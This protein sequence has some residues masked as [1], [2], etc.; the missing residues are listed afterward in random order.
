[1]S[2]PTK[3][4][5][6]TAF[7]G[8]HNG[9]SHEQKRQ[10]RRRRSGKVDV[11]NTPS[12]SKTTASPAALK[13]KTS[14]KPV[15]S[16]LK[17]KDITTPNTPTSNDGK[18]KKQNSAK[19]PTKALTPN[20]KPSDSSKKLKEA[21]AALDK[22]ITAEPQ[23][24]A[25]TKNQRKKSTSL[26]SKSSHIQSQL[27]G[28]NGGNAEG[29]DLRSKALANELISEGPALKSSKRPRKRNTNPLKKR[30]TS[31][32]NQKLDHLARTTQQDQFVKREQKNQLVKKDK[33]KPKAL[34]NPKT[35]KSILIGGG[36]RLS[37]GNGGMF[38][39]QDP[40]LTADGQYLILPTHS[41]IQVYSTKTSLL[42]RSF[43]V[44]PRSDITCCSL[45]KADPKKLYV[46]SSRGL[47]SLWDWTAAAVIG[48]CNAGN[49]S[50]QVLPLCQQEDKETI[51]V[52]QIDAQGSRRLAA[53]SVNTILGNFTESDTVLQRINLSP[54]FKSYAQGT[55]LLACV[56]NQLLIGQCQGTA[57]GQLDF[58]YIWREIT[59]PGFITSFDAQVNSGKSKTS[60][61]VPFLDVVIGLNDGAIVHY[62]DIL[63]KLI[64]KEKKN[65]ASTEDIV[66][67]KLHW[68]R[69]A[70]NTV[71]WSRDRNYI[72]SGGN[73]TVLVI[74]QLDSNQRQYLP[75]LSTPILN[76]SV[77]ASGSSYALRL[78]D[79]S[80]MILSTADLLPSTNVCGLALGMSQKN[81]SPLL[82]HPS[83]PNRLLA[84]V[85]S[86]AGA[87]GPFHGRYST[88]LQVYDV[89]SNIQVGRQALTR[90][91]VTASNVAPTGQPVK[92]PTVTQI[93]VSH[94]GRWLATVDEWQPNEQDLDSTYIRSDCTDVRGR[95]TET[96][97]R[98]WLWNE[99]NNNFEQVTRVDEPHTAG[100]NSVLGVSFNPA[101]LELATT[102]SD[103]TVRIWSPKARHRNGVSVRNKANEQLYTWSCS[104]TIQCDHDAPLERGGIDAKAISAALTYAEDG[105]VVAAAWFWPGNRSRLLEES[106]AATFKGPR[107]RFVH[108]ID[109]ATG[110]IVSSEPSL[111]PS[112]SSAAKLLFHS[113]YLI[114]LSQTL[115]ILDTITN[116]LVSSPIQLDQQYVP[117]RSWSPFY[118]T[119][120]KFDGTIA[121]CLS[122][123]EKPRGSKLV[124]LTLSNDDSRDTVAGS[125][126]SPGV[127]A[128]V[129]YQTSFNG[130]VKG[131]L[132]LTTGPGYLIIDERNQYRFLRPTV[133]AFT[134]TIAGTRETEQVTRSLDSI[135]GRQGLVAPVTA[136]AREEVPNTA[137]NTV[138]AHVG[139]G[140]GL[141]SVLR[142]SSSAQAPTPTELFQRV[143]GVLAQGGEIELE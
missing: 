128:K 13:A 56:E 20:Q 68:H 2:Q 142:F 124:L 41:E 101:K 98:L 16:T 116:R 69:T 75:H 102:G 90:N 96:S 53:Y 74:W 55:V 130:T 111:L 19:T 138:D 82:A 139:G 34:K 37:S 58:T 136:A 113:R 114:C 100:P 133:G 25:G 81:S 77:S 84:A 38:I 18:P 110:K 40:I 26:E 70:V 47:V 6:D 11:E 109:P 45:S 141:N 127:Q 125:Q 17:A 15:N 10:R 43:R 27:T 88:L 71:K 14:N 64:G 106:S 112:T 122:R 60:R 86:D 73:E 42:V 65:K 66:G 137:V 83:V 67:R 35:E 59:V 85:P 104:R 107:T 24:L 32:E 50:L 7:E 117:P 121:I 118:I 36:F 95:S 120:N 92:E 4:D 108:L 9:S 143:V 97:L 52:L 91:M 8:N 46:S 48:K 31:T 123:S 79:N 63:F 39:D 1:M 72:I 33:H 87:T 22:G 5:A 119:K 140:G 89:E 135:F 105:S 94:D 76:L 3:R 62:E 131:L 61:K 93:A 51:L 49:A 78:G 134:G 126:D 132:A 23:N 54:C 57:E 129:V 80:V 44:D 29:S 12:L 28:T 30:M 21:G 99:E 115:T 103:A